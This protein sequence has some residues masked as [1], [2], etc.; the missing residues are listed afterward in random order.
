MDGPRAKTS[1]AARDAKLQNEPEKLS[2]AAD[3]C[4]QSVNLY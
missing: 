1:A 3:L 4:E 2:A